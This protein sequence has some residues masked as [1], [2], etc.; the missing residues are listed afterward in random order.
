MVENKK[1]YPT[2][3][4]FIHETYGTYYQLSI[5]SGVSA[6]AKKHD[7]NLVIVCGS[8]LNT[9]RPN[10]RYANL[11]YDWIGAENVDGVIITSTLFNHIGREA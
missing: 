4:L 2:I 10:F 3:A 7:L 1:T 5:I 11:L 8:E 9:A 6:A